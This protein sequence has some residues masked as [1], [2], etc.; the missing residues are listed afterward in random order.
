MLSRLSPLLFLAAGASVAPQWTAAGGPDGQPRETGDLVRY[1]LE[2]GETL[3]ELAEEHFLSAEDWRKARALNGPAADTPGAV[4]R[5]D[6]GWLRRTPLTAEVIAFRG[7]SVATVAGV[8]VPVRRGLV[9]AEGD[10]IRTGSAGHATL[11]LPDGSLLSL[12]TNSGIRFE[13]LRRYSLNGALDRRIRV[14]AGAVDNRVTPLASETSRYEVTTDL[15]VAA[16]RGTMFRIAF[17]PG[18]MGAEVTEGAVGVAGNRAR[19]DSE[20]RLDAGFGLVVGPAGPGQPVRLPVAPVFLSLPS[21]AGGAAT[22][23]AVRAEPRLSYRAV[24]ATDPDF[25][26]RVAETV[27]ADGRF[28]FDGLAPGRYHA[29][30]SAVLPSGLAGPP[31]I[32]QFDRGAIPVLAAAP[33]AP[34][35]SAAREPPSPTDAEGKRSAAPGPVASGIGPQASGLTALAAAA[36]EIVGDAGSGEG[37]ADMADT[38]ATAWSDVELHAGA[39]SRLPARLPTSGGRGPAFAP[40]AGNSGATFGGGGGGFGLLP[41]SG[42]LAVVPAS[43]PILLPAAEAVALPAAPVPAG[44]GPLTLAPDPAPSILPAAPPPAP[45]PASP[46]PEPAAWAQL[47]AGFALLGAMLRRARARVRPS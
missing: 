42:P 16:V 5:L 26:D 12:P 8:D 34:P 44:P 3:P 31:A 43:G 25:L 24:V 38:P 18:R 9:L 10:R 17:T 7:A 15:G 41:A 30:V 22:D 14:E 4:L 33:A 13:R 29:A 35:P 19:P 28:R 40:P 20:T 23:L 11:R 46:T 27:S 45:S 36:E 32:T 6:T 39:W 21:A 47:L 1:T 37:D 2:E